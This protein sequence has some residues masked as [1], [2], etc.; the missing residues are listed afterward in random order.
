MKNTISLCMIS[1][2][3]EENIEKCLVSVKNA[4][5]EIILVDTGS[6]D[7]TVD[8]AEKYNAKV[9]CSKWQNDFSL[10]R[11]ISL[12][13]AS[14]SFILFLDCDEV[15]DKKSIKILKDT[16]NHGN[17]DAYYVTLKNY[18][19]DNSFFVSRS[20][21][22]FKNKK[23]IRFKGKIHEQLTGMSSIGETEITIS[24]YG[25]IQNKS[26][27]SIK[28]KRNL[29]I[30]NSYK[31]D[32]KNNFY[33]YNLGVEYLRI[34]NMQ[35][36]EK[37]FLKSLK[38]VDLKSSYAPSLMEKF[39][40]L[41]MIS[42]KYDTAVKYA[43]TFEKIYSDFNDLYYLEALSDINKGNYSQGALLLKKFCSMKDCSNK[44]PHQEFLSKNELYEYIKKIENN[45]I[46]KKGS[47]SVCIAAKN[48]ELTI[49]NCIRSINEI[50]DEVIVMD[51]GSSDRTKYICKEMGA[52]VYDEK[53][54]DDFSSIRNLA[55]SKASGNWV[56]F[57]NGNEYIS[58][59]NLLKIVEETSN[60]KYDGYI[61]NIQTG[62]LNQGRCRLFKNKG[63]KYK[64][65]VTEDICSSIKASGG[66][67]AFKDIKIEHIPSKNPEKL[68]AIKAKYDEDILLSKFLEGTYY[69]F[70]NNFA[71]AA[72]CFE[73]CIKNN[74]KKA[75]LYYLYALVLIKCHKT[76]KASDIAGIGLTLYPDYTDVTYIKGIASFMKKDI[77]G[78][79]K[80]F[81]RCIAQ[82]ESPITKYDTFSGCG[83]FK[84]QE[85]LSYEYSL[86]GNIDKALN[87]LKD[88]SK[89]TEHFDEAIEKI[90]EIF[91][92][93]KT[94]NEL[95]IF[96]KKNNLYNERSRAAV[97]KTCARLKLYNESLQFALEDNNLKSLDSLLNE[98]LHDFQ[99]SF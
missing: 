42:R 60:E 50:A 13:N 80:L 84:A 26:M 95:K 64:D 40:T 70:E 20:L 15:L 33:Y 97:S 69:T 99:I 86:T 87:I 21:R 14:G 35:K 67:V 28:S 91:A 22:L 94:I 62:L 3:E 82:G 7:H 27:I 6:N 29:D 37:C 51:Y 46:N 85:S 23:S 47:I 65:N 79:I 66:N 30:L 53:W 56:L 96:L 17:C 36:A 49:E 81:E 89:N 43:E 44:Y 10:A 57:L 19:D 61:L 54:N 75:E 72:D 24:H 9:I 73:Y 92:K 4:V 25:Y 48:N 78:S 45:C 41:L 52:K 11:N 34:Y 98:L 39:L 83:S 2:N 58:S 76:D 59:E 32:E 90:T 55:I 18:S 8:I 71:D 74:F 1:K 38:N 68:Q 77:T 31:D 88:L 5:N 16:I 63:Y 12:N 93:F